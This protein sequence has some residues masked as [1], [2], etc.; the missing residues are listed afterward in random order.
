MTDDLSTT[1]TK[2]KREFYLAKAQEAEEAAR[3][4]KDSNEHTLLLQIVQSWRL[5]AGRFRD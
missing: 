4:A 3:Q 2:N 1:P 5:L